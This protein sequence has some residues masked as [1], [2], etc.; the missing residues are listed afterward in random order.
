MSAPSPYHRIGDAA[1]LSGVPAAN[2][3]YYEKEGLLPAQARADNRY[4][5]YSDDEIHRLRFI[6]LCR[7]MDMSLEEVR[8]LLSLGRGP[9]S[10][11]DHAA[12]ATVD[13][14]LLHVRTR[15]QELQALEAQL[16]S[17]RGRCDGA[18]G[19]PCRVIDA[20][21]ARADAQPLPSPEPLARRHV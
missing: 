9:G 5:L 10:A 4:R 7:A 3:R 2:I 18:D 16:L 21:H 11:A 13:E 20:L 15:L 12:C 19:S 14:H 8:T 1:R 17:L 6:R